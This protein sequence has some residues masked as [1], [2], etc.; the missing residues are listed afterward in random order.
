MNMLKSFVALLFLATAAFCGGAYAQSQQ[1]QTQNQEQSEQDESAGD[2]Y[3]T[4]EYTEELDANQQTV[5]IDEGEEGGGGQTEE[6][7]PYEGDSKPA[8]KIHIYSGKHDGNNVINPDP[9]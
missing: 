3:G 4:E 7:T 9:K 2:E 5:T 6:E 1:T 8:T